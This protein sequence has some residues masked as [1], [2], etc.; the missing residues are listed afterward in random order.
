[1]KKDLV[2]ERTV[3][4]EMLKT[5]GSL[6][7]SSSNLS[8]TSSAKPQTSQTTQ[9]T[10]QTTAEPSSGSSFVE[11]EKEMLELKVKVISKKTINLAT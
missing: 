4:V 6:N 2:Q 7:P 9:T 3:V 5:I 10:S 11:K 1:M 8:T